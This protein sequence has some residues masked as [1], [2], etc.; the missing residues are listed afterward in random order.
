MKWEYSI[1]DLGRATFRQTEADLL[2]AAAHDG[3]ELV[4]VIAPVRAVMKRALLDQPEGA[5]GARGP[6]T[7]KYR[8]PATGD[9][10]SGRGK[11]ASWL[12]EKVRAGDQIQRYLVE[13][14]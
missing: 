7:V 13:Q 2:N 1:I 11:M 3:W 9:T 4:Q 14:D 12:A 8:D 10:W 5:R 6:A